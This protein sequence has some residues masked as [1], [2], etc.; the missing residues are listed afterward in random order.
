[1]QLDEIRDTPVL[2]E[3]LRQERERLMARI[4]SGAL[5][6]PIGTAF[7]QE[8]SDL[9]DAVIRRMFLLACQRMRTQPERV[10]VAIIATGGYGRRELA[11]FSDVDI[12]FVPQRDND[13][14]TDRVIRDLFTQLMEVCI[15]GCGLDVGYAY[16][17]LSDCER[18]DHQTSSGLLDARLIA[19]NERLFIQFEDAYWTG[20]NPTEFIFTKREERARALQK[21]GTTPFVV[22]PNLKEGAGGLRDLQSAVWLLQARYQ[23]VAARVRGDRLAMA[24][25]EKARLSE[26]EIVCLLRARDRLLRTRAA[27]HAAT[28]GARDQLVV[29]R[30]EEVA[31]LLGYDT[32]SAAEGVPP[33]ERFMADLYRDLALIRQT[34][35]RIMERVANSRLFLGIGLDCRRG[36]IVPANGALECEDPIWLLWACELAQKYRLTLSE[37]IKKAAINLVEMRPVLTHPQEAGQIFTRILSGPNVY[38]TLQQ[39]SDLGILGWL[40]PEF[41]C[42]LTLIPY[43]PSHDY[44]VGQH[45]LFVI[46]NLEA[47]RHT[48]EGEDYQEM[49]RLFESLPHPEQLMLAALLHDCGKAI[50]GRPHAETGAEIAAKV[51]ARLGWSREASENVQ[52]LV[53]HHLLMAETSRLRDPTLEE[54]IRDFTRVV[55]DL[56]RLHMLYLLT[57][58]DTRAVGAGVWTQVKGR[59]LRELWQ[60]AAAV[61]MEEEP[62]GYD[63]ATVARARRRLLK[64]LSLA[65]L[66]E[67]EV[68][69][70]VQAMPPHYLLNQSLNRIA[71]HIEFVRRVRQG[72]IVIDFHDERDASY[73]ELTV[74]TRDDPRP[75]LLAKIAGA[76]YAADLEVHSAQVL[77]RVTSR[78]RIALDTLWVDFRGR[79]LTP[80]KKREVAANLNAVLSG[81]KSL[82]ELLARP[83]Y[84]ER[85]RLRERAQ[86]ASER[87]IVVRSVRNDLS[88]TLTVIETSGPDTR[89]AFGMVARGLSWLGWDIRSARVSYWQGEARASFYVSGARD[90]TEETVAQK[91]AQTL[92]TPDLMATAVEPVETLVRKVP[93]E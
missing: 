14:L 5:K 60:R 37:K 4:L 77:T 39:M 32:V 73:T 61:L 6:R 28:Q 74:C 82:P 3:Y 72:E 19:G 10:P 40:I 91:L 55:N 57:Y 53:R 48:S 52:F 18:L 66:P 87:A 70:H 12:T 79:P 88:D 29:T 15:N 8:W 24:L 75:G 17:L 21:W 35:D 92:S 62:V 86:S 69:E 27:L 90:L 43:D 84:Q 71:L 45:S 80:N 2:A 31:T 58:A 78:D 42:T 85:R 23:L 47:L 50:P 46:Q 1:M 93:H 67:A 9:M 11:P 56:D 22:E 59:F 20:F 44:T 83:R 76:L 49:R 33:V 65:N 7:A 30:Q 36:Q 34:A 26:N 54:T 25:T 81:Q 63:D 13:P 51:C 16:R 38:A 41:E 68:A 89:S 64:D